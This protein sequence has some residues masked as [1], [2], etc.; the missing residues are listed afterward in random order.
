MIKINKIFCKNNGDSPAKGIVI[1]IHGFGEHAGSYRE[2]AE[3]FAAANYSSVTF[4]QRGH[5]NLEDPRLRGIIPGYQCFLDDIKT[6]HT[7]I[8]Q[9]APDIP[10]VLYGHSMGGNIAANYILAYPDS[11]LSCAVLE[12]PWFGLH[13]EPSALV[14]GFAS[15][16]GAVSPKLAT[17]SRLAKSDVTSDTAKAEEMDRDPL[18]H[19]RISFRMVTGIKKACEN[20]INNASQISIPVFLAYAEHE[21]IVSNRAIQDFYSRC[22][23][24]VTIKEYASCHAIHNDVVRGGFYSDVTAFIGAHCAN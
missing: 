22:S 9:D 8:K 16:L 6:V 17:V 14:Y 13:K 12:S 18:Y 2:L 4:D 24:N 23:Q 5:G 10:V 11:G 20:A 19:N 3:R 7:Q 21:R 15:V 1:I